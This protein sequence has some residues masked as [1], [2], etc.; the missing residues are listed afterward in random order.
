[1]KSIEIY[2]NQVCKLFPVCFKE[3]KIF[4]KNFKKQLYEFGN[5]TKNCSFDLIVEEFGEPKE[6]VKTYYDTVDYKRILN[7]IFYKKF[8]KL[9][10]IIFLCFCVVY[11]IFILI[12]GIEIIENTVQ[13]NVLTIE[14]D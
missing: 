2:Y 12:T 7:R 3:E 13:R 4:L 14:I 10:T 1:M 6:I 9:L 5:S 8:I 11:L